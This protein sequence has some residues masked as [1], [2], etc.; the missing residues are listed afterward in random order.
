MWF[1]CFIGEKSLLSGFFPSLSPSS[2]PPCFS[3]FSP[4]R[5]S[6]LPFHSLLV[7]ILSRF[8]Y[9]TQHIRFRKI[10]L[11]IFAES[12]IFLCHGGMYGI[13]S[14]TWCLAL[15][16]NFMVSS[17]SSNVIYATTTAVLAVFGCC[18]PSI[19]LSN[20]QQQQQQQIRQD[21]LPFFGL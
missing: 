9:I 2:H 11:F 1:Q 6:S 7:F 17:V 12:V 14:H 16:R 19:C 13:Q 18:F 8:D 3:L 5:F 10:A 21:Y 4:L 15:I 20:N